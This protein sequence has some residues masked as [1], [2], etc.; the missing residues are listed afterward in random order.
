MQ[1]HQQLVRSLTVLRDGK[2]I[3]SVSYDNI[4]MWKEV[5]Q[6]AQTNNNELKK[7]IKLK[8]FKKDDADDNKG[9]FVC[10]KRKKDN[11]TP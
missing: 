9:L 4:K 1:A 11:T 7:G 5:D 2:T 6:V 10:C 8:Q 3:I